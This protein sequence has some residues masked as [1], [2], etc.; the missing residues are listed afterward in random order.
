MNKFTHSDFSCGPQYLIKRTCKVEQNQLITR[1]SYSVSSKSISYISHKSYKIISSTGT[2]RPKASKSVSKT[3][4]PK[5]ASSDKSLSPTTSRSSRSITKLGSKF[6]VSGTVIKKS[7]SVMTRSKHDCLSKKPQSS[8]LLSGSSSK[9][10]LKN[11]KRERK[12]GL[13]AGG[14]SDG[15]FDVDSEDS[16]K[17]MEKYRPCDCDQRTQVSVDVWSWQNF[18]MVVACAV[19]VVLLV[20]APLI[21]LGQREWW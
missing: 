15:I 12:G 6:K 10:Q 20:S 4:F 17:H 3:F 19:V 1:Q 16:L 14:L 9:I 18:R 21:F 11:R 5:R 7:G 13:N 2:S 8:N